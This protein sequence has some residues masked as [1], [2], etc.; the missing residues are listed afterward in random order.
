[1]KTQG[2]GNYA[3]TVS[4]NTRDR[5]LTL[6]PKIQSNDP[7]LFDTAYAVEDQDLDALLGPVR[8]DSI[9]EDA[10]NDGL[11][12]DTLFYD[13]FQLPKPPTKRQKLA[14]DVSGNQL[15]QVEYNGSIPRNHSVSPPPGVCTSTKLI[16]VYLITRRIRPAAQSCTIA[17]TIGDCR[18]AT[19]A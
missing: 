15:L 10:R 1:M 2:E 3:S 4:S 14:R 19:R 16:S 13:S 8:F 6:S 5:G 7:W 11:D 9:V 12:I 18:I 17:C